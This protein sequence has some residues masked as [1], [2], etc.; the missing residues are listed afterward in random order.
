MEGV[1]GSIPTENTNE[2]IMKYVE[3]NVGDTV[4][5]HGIETRGGENKLTQGKVV[6][7][8]RP[9]GYS[10]DQ[11]VVEIPTHIDPLL[12]VRDGFTVSDAADKP[13]G[14]YRRAN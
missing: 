7:I 1:V 9:E 14:I 4:W 11:Y 5:I 13:I 3:A 6:H 8:F 10:M 2:V 12:E